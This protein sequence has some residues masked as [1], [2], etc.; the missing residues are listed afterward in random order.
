MKKTFRAKVMAAILA[1]V[2]AVSACAA[3][4]AV[5]ANAA[6]INTS[7]STSAATPFYQTLWGTDWNYSADSTCAK[8]TCEFDYS[9]NLCKFKATGVTPGV[10][11][12]VLKVQIGTGKWKNFP[13]RFTV[14]KNL[15]VSGVQNG[16]IYYTT[17]PAPVKS[18][19][20]RNTNT[21]TNTNTN[22]NTNTGNTSKTSAKSCS[23]TMTGCD[24]N[25]RAD[26]TNVKIT[27][28]FDYS[29]SSCKFIGTAVKPGVTN[30]TLKAQRADGKWN[31]TPV[32]FTVDNSLN[33]KVVKTGNVYVTDN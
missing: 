17:V 28:D 26:N 7:A 21:N 16:M 8:I 32:H 33:I 10:T 30:A 20:N 15:S 31:N 18:A 6:S 29:K 2:C 13:I 3:A 27:C 25:Y 11:N 9:R 23:Y 24:W 4:T 22:S 14:S 19:E 5:T 12:A 1:A